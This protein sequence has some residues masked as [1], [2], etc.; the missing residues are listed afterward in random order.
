MRSA[1]AVPEQRLG[2]TRRGFLVGASNAAVFGLAGYAVMRH[3]APQRQTEALPSEAPTLP[4]E[5]AESLEVAPVGDRFGAITQTYKNFFTMGN[6]VMFVDKDGVEVGK[7]A[8]EVIDGELPGKGFPEHGYVTDGYAKDWLEAA[9]AQVAQAKGVSVDTLVPRTNWD[10]LQKAAANPKETMTRED[11]E[12]IADIARYFGEKPVRGGD[13]LSRIEY[14]REQVTFGGNLAET[15]AGFQT[16][17]RRLLPGLCAVESGFNDA[18]TSSAGARGIFQFMPNTWHKDLGREAFKVDVPVPLVE[19]VAAAGELFS[20]MYNRIRYW[21]HEEPNWQGRNFLEDIKQL[22][23]SQ[24]A[25]EEQFL[26]P[27]LV[28]AYNVG[29]KGMGEVIQAFAQSAEFHSLQ[30]EGVGGHDVFQVMTEFGFASDH[31]D[32]DDYGPEAS[33]YVQKIYAFAEVLDTERE[34]VVQVASN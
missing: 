5:P 18:V 8:V 21:S 34:E 29:E 25:F 33:T 15:S 6:E 10:M 12:S 20:K 14:V 26:L 32:L 31:P 27:C 16:A 3:E 19:Q 13:G 11:T 28:N 30:Q 24:E 1:P 2:M 22:F 4:P 9:K 7:V 23:P 17:L